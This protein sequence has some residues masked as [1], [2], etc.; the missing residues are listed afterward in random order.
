MTPVL[1][2]TLSIDESWLLDKWSSTVCLI[3]FNLEYMRVWGLLLQVTLFL[4]IESLYTPAIRGITNVFSLLK[5]F[6]W[7]QQAKKSWL[8][9]KYEFQQN[10][11]R[12][13]GVTA[14]M[15]PGLTAMMDTDISWPWKGNVAI[16]L[17]SSEISTKYWNRRK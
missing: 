15:F 14:I 7:R 4:R 1:W 2:L 10:L 13:P 6:I 8:F 11:T 5:V 9:S 12:S 16:T 17:S 3:W